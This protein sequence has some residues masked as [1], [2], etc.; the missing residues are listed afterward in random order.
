MCLNKL[1]NIY[2]WK[3]NNGGGNK[4]INVMKQMANDER[5]RT[6]K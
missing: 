6:K 3:Y 4:S 1:D 5:S 2:G